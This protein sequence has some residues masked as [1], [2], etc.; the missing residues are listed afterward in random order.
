MLSVFGDLLIFSPSTL[1][2]S[3]ED[4]TT[5]TAATTVDNFG[6]LSNLVER[7]QNG[8]GV[9]TNDDDLTNVMERSQPGYG[10]AELTT[11]P[12]SDEARND[13]SETVKLVEK[14]VVLVSSALPYL[15]KLC[16]WC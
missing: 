3:A 10:V 16:F 15:N 1:P 8:V 7:P 12:S 9:L 13:D 14:S 2:S 11:R 4:E 5:T 6:I